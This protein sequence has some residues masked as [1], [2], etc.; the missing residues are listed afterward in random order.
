MKTAAGARRRPAPPSCIACS[1]RT[2]PRRRNVAAP[3]SRPGPVPRRRPNRSDPATLHRRFSLCDRRSPPHPVR[4]GQPA[5]GGGATQGRDHV[6]HLRRRQGSAERRVR[7]TPGR[8]RRRRG[9]QRRIGRRR[10]RRR[11]R[12]PRKQDRGRA[13]KLPGTR[14]KRH[15]P[16][17][18]AAI[19]ILAHGDAAD[20]VAAAPGSA[21]VLPARAKRATTQMPTRRRRSPR[22]TSIAKMRIAGAKAGVATTP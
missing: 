12:T 10:D 15:P 6:R 4:A 1:S 20:R 16:G 5:P 14:A 13:R 21:G 19:L 8:G 3:P 22:A 7:R 9:P 18:G 2:P 11:R 17:T